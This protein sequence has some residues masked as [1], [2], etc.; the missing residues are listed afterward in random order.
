MWKLSQNIWGDGI[1]IKLTP[2]G[3]QKGEQLLATLA[4]EAQQ[5]THNASDFVRKLSFAQLVSAIYKA[6]PEMKVNSVFQG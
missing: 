5:F 6:Y 2:E 3:Q 4:S 1:L